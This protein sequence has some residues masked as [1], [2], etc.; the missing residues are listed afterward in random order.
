M[1]FI[2]KLVEHPLR[3]MGVEPIPTWGISEYAHDFVHAE[4]LRDIF[5]MK[6]IDCVFDVGAHNGYTGKFLRKNVGFT[7]TILSFEP[8]PVPFKA[9]EEASRGDKHWHTFPIALGAQPGE[10]EMN[11]MNKLLFSSFLTPSTATPENMASKNTVESK[12]NV[13]VERLSDLYDELADKHDFNR[14]FLKMD[15]QGFDLQVF[16]GT[17]PRIDHFLGLQS[18]VSVIQIYKGM[19]DWEEALAKYKMAGFSLSGF[20]PVS[21]DDQLRVVEFDAVMVRND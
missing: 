14:P 10:F 18:E 11:V 4:L 13:R 8:L 12:I 3:A 6:K 19:P 7:G 20:F 5:E 1:G 15:T 9:L 16:E 21:H 2:R 17:L